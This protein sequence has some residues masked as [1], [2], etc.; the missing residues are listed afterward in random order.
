MLL[1][2]VGKLLDVIDEE[3]TNAVEQ[4]NASTGLIMVYRGFSFASR[5]HV[6]YL[7]GEGRIFIKKI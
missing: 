6:V 5:L 4:H 3:T 2:F 1:I 7:A